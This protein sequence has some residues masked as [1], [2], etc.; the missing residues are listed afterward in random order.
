MALWYRKQLAYE[1]NGGG[2]AN[3]KELVMAYLV[4][5]IML[6]LVMDLVHSIRK[7]KRQSRHLSNSR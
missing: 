7:K 2:G 1:N 4:G 3:R 5:F 6:F